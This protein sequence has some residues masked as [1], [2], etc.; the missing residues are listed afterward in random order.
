MG[1]P[2]PKSVPSASRVQDP[3]EIS[4]PGDVQGTVTPDCSAT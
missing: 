2:P 3:V 4:R 1:E